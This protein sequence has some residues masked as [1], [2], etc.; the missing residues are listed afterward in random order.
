MG[1][2]EAVKAVREQRRL[3]K[4]ELAERS[5]LAASYL[6][7]LEA[8]DYRSP[9]IETLTAVAEGLEMDPR[10]LLVL[11]GYVPEEESSAGLALAQDEISRTAQDAI[12]R[13]AEIAQAATEE[14]K[15]GGNREEEGAGFDGSL[16]Q[17]ASLL[18]EN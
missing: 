6:S 18:A 10:D 3:S 11:G 7:R 13:I 14:T 1:F 4:A 2:A 8:G 16:W 12:R 5:G 9:S 15:G 17:N